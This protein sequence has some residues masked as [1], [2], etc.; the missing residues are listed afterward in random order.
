MKE[1]DFLPKMT[2]F[3][4]AADSLIWG[5][6]LGKDGDYVLNAPGWSPQLK[7]PGVSQVVDEHQATYNKSAEAL[8]GAAY[9][10]VQVLF[11]AVNRAGKPDRS[12]V[13]DAIAATNMMTVAG[14]VTFNPDGT[15]PMITVFNQWLSS[16]QALVWPKDQAPQPPSFP[17]K[18]WTDR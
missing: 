11:D 7:F 14:P 15:S 16:K 12:A 2:I 4:R 5:Q 10:A 1:L 6:N 3:I 9:A 18:A 17:A 8:V 13:R